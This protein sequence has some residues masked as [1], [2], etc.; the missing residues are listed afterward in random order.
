VRRIVDGAGAR[1]TP[2]APLAW[3]RY[4]PHREPYLG[5]ELR[6]TSWP[7]GEDRSLALCGY[8]GDPVEWGPAPP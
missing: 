2:A 7:G 6:L 5:A 8:H 3:L 1:A 4:E